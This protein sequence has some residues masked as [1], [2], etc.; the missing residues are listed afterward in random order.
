M[1]IEYLRDS[2]VLNIAVAIFYSINMAFSLWER[3]P[4]VNIVLAACWQGL[5]RRR[6]IPNKNDKAKRDPQIFNFQSSIFNSGLS[7]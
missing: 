1:K 7:G 5:S 2:V 4:A 6:V 3:L